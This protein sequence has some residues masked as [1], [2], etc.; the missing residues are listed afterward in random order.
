MKLSP[1]ELKDLR[2]ALYLAV[3]YEDSVIDS[4]SPCK[5][6]PGYAASVH[7]HLENIKRFTA[8]REKLVNEKR[9]RLNLDDPR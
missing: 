1:N 8:L 9:K 4:Y 5:G 2:L 6:G 7:D 3:E